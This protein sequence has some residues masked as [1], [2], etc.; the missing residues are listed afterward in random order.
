MAFNIKLLVFFGISALLINLIEG[1]R[2]CCV[3][4]WKG[5][6]PL[7]D[8]D[9]FSNSDP[10]VQMYGIYQTNIN[11]YHYIYT[12][13]TVWDNETPYWSDSHC[14][15]FVDYDY[16]YFQ[17]LDEDTTTGPDFMADTN[18]QDFEL[19][20][21]PCDAGWITSELVLNSDGDGEQGSL[22]I[23]TECNCFQEVIAP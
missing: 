23:K 18:Y 21:I 14:M 8:L 11:Q 16:L 13:S 7:I 12:T 3:F 19:D 9:D 2:N 22:W 20:E 17:I 6:G 10:Y 1:G 15:T 5:T 4:I